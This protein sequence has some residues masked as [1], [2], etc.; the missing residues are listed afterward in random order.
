MK[1]NEIEQERASGREIDSEAERSDRKE[2]SA[3]L[4]KFEFMENG[5]K[6]FNREF[7]F[8]ENVPK[9]SKKNST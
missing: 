6:D 7:E 5:P 4:K 1:Q 2:R 3:A 9:A 8:M